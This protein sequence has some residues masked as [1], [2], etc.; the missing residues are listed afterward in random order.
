MKFTIRERLRSETVIMLVEIVVAGMYVFQ[1][2]NTIVFEFTHPIGFTI[3]ILIYGACSISI[4][5][6]VSHGSLIP[7]M[8][9]TALAIAKARID[10][11]DISKKLRKYRK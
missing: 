9:W 8:T 5:Y 7:T 6:H 10:Y 3:S 2:L 1:K 11:R 4:I